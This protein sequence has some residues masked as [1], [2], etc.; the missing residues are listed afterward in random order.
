MPRRF[1]G[2]KSAKAGSFHNAYGVGWGS[3]ALAILVPLKLAGFLRCS[4]WWITA[5]LW[6][7]ALLALLWVL[8]GL[9]LAGFTG[10]PLPPRPSRFGSSSQ[11]RP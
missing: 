7:S 5:P 4:W 10:A 2:A 11:R 1:E 8:Y 3:V 9:L 6:G